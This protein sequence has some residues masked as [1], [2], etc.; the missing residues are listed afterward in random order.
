MKATEFVKSLQDIAPHSKDLVRKGFSEDYIRQ[1]VDSFHAAP[2]P[3]HHEYDNEL[4]NL[5]H[6]Y[7]ASKIEITLVHF[8]LKDDS[9]YGPPPSERFLRVGYAEADFEPLVSVDEIGGYR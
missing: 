2:R 3:V 8:D 7:N 1:L 5:I 6:N 9:P 4:L